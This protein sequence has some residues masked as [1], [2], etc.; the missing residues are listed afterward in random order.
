MVYSV[1]NGRRN[2]IPGCRTG[3]PPTEEP[4]TA[5]NK[6][7]PELVTKST[8]FT[9]PLIDLYPQPEKL[10]HFNLEFQINQTHEIVLVPKDRSR[11]PF[12]C[13]SF[14]TALETG[15]ENDNEKTFGWCGVC[16]VNAKQNSE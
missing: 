1:S 8:S 11:P 6:L 14:D 15:A 12:L 5:M 16:D 13:Y 4:C 10:N 9:L 2:L 3:R 7:H